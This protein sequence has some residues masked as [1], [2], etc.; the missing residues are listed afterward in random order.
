[1]VLRL[2]H[3]S[4]WLL[5]EVIGPA[6][7]REHAGTRPRSYGRRSLAVARAAWPSC[8]TTTRGLRTLTASDTQVS[9]TWYVSTSIGN[10]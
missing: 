4:A 2:I 3:M 9:T 10:V 7:I 5:Y 1:M 6:W 8:W